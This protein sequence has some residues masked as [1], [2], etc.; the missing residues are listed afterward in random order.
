MNEGS[1]AAAIQA[2]TTHGTHETPHMQELPRS[3]NLSTMEESFAATTSQ[4][5]TTRESLNGQQSYLSE[6]ATSNDSIG[7][8][9]NSLSSS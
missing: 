6:T 5:S 8:Y 2:Q 9:P 1:A 3:R 4:T 7:T